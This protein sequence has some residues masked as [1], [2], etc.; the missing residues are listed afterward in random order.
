MS[1]SPKP[2]T[3]D[4]VHATAE[5]RRVWAMACRHSRRYFGLQVLGARIGYAAGFYNAYFHFKKLKA[6]MRKKR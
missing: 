5:E 4:W 3:R 1:K 2:N 6:K